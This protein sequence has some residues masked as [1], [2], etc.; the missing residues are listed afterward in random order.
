MPAIQ[1]S[2]VFAA[3]LGLVACTSGGSPAKTGT[4]GVGPA[5]TGGTGSAGTHGNAGAS[6]GANGAGTAGAAGGGGGPTGSGAAG[7][8]A[9]GAS[10]GASGGAGG[11]GGS[12]GGAAGGATDGGAGATGGGNQDGSIARGDGPL[13]T[14]GCAGK[15]YQL[16]IDF[17][18]GLD[19]AVWT[20]NAKGI[21]TTD[22][23]H[24]GH[25]FHA[26]PGGAF[27]KTTKMGTIKNVVWGR[28]YVHM[29]PG[30]PGGHGEI[31][32]VYDTSGDWY[33]IGWQFNGILGNWHGLGGEKPLRS[34]PY[35][36]DKWYCIEFLFDG[37][38]GV[39]PQWWID[40]SE[41]QYYMAVPAAKGPRMET[42][43]THLE[44]GMTSFA[45][46]GLNQQPYGN[47]NP[48]VMTDLWID[49]VAFDTQRIGCIE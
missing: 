11:A 3:V 5:G 29:K 39:M 20:G 12:S 33:E 14:A 38:A 40:G 23:A 1:K 35:I 6:A 43:F 25:S 46:L 2:V 28:F 26:Y 30:A 47:S 27:L 9:A 32:G 45:G 4:A 42:Q 49:D 44:V 34:M 41:A 18:S 19:T 48:P 8:G 15:N 21:D 37:A 17:E 7:S 22:F 16:C 31:V 10:A 36:V 24:G 13:T